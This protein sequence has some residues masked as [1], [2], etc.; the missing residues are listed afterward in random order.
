MDIHE[1]YSNSDGYGKTVYVMS[2]QPITYINWYENSSSSS[3][4]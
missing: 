3:S 4:S 2:T 1:W